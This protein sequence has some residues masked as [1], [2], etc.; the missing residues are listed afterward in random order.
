MTHLVIDTGPLVALLN[1]KDRHHHG[2][3]D[4]LDTV[5]SPVHTC[6]AVLSE[7]CL[8]LARIPDGQDAVLALLARGILKVD[9]RIPSEAD[10]LRELMRKFSSVP[11]SLA[12]ACLV[13]MSD[14][15]PKCRIPT[16]DSD[17]RIYRRNRR[18]TIPLNMP[19]RASG[20]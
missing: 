1:R 7:A 6:E 16:L 20:G 13:R 14:L 18:Q 2:V 19:G 11:M 17:F 10:A 8:L 4:N 3:R 12:D 9:F 5:E 15:E